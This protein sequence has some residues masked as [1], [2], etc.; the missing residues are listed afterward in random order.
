MIKLNSLTPEL[1]ERIADEVASYRIAAEAGKIL[2]Q[3]VIDGIRESIIKEDKKLAHDA[4]FNAR[5][6]SITP[7]EGK[8][9]AMLKRIWG[10][11]ERILIANI[12]KMKKAWLHKDKIDDILYSSAIFEK[13][14]ANG[15][16]D[17]AVEVMTAEGKRVVSIYDFD[18]IFDVQNPEVTKWLKSYMPVFSEKLEEVSAKKLRATLIEGI[19]AGEGVPGLTNRVYEI[20]K[21]WGFTR[22]ETIAQNQVIRASN[23]G[24]L[25]VYRQSGVVKKKIWITHF[26]ERTCAHCEM[27]D[28]RVIGLETNFFDLGDEST[29]KVDGKEQVLKMNYEEIEGPPLHTQCRCAVG[30]VVD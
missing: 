11:E 26:D 8:F 3:M 17:I 4:L 13:K 1:A 25:N 18:M 7:F 30:A 12:K 21:D 22:A 16:T 2:K 24:A 5:D 29:V 10:E 27:M 20:Y 23:K 9:K 15:A 19:E 6:K 14:L 28:G